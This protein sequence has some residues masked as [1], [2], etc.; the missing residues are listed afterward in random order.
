MNLGWD[1]ASGNEMRLGSCD[2][3]VNGNA[4]VNESN[5]VLLSECGECAPYR[6]HLLR[7]LLLWAWFCSWQVREKSNGKYCVVMKTER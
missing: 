5:C 7:L 1:F 2:G 4:S 3:H 6:H